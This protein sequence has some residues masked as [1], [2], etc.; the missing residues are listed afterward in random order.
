[1]P[2]PAFSTDLVSVIIP[3]YNH[4]KY[5]SKSIDSVL[6]QTHPYIEVVVVDDGSSDATREVSAGY[7][8]VK[9]IY[10]QNR[11]LSAARNTGID[12]SSG[13]YLVFLDADDWLFPDAVEIN[14]SYLRN[15]PDAGF[16][17]GA[18]TLVQPGIN[19]E[20]MATVEGD[21]YQ[22]LLRGNYI[23]MHATVMY[24]RNVFDGLRFDPSMR[25]CEDYDVY[26]KAARRFP[27]LHHTKQI[28]VYMIHD[29]NMSGNVP[30]MLDT[31]LKALN[32]Q[33]PE[34]RSEAEKESFRVG[35][36]FWINHYTQLMYT[37]LL[38]SSDYRR[39]AKKEAGEAML[40]QYRKDLYRKYQIL[41]PFMPLKKAMIRSKA[42]FLLRWLYKTG[43]YRKF[44]PAVGKISQGDFNRT[45]PFSKAF[46]YE[47]GGPVDRYY[48]ENFLQRNAPFIKGRVLEIGDN[49]YTL[50]YGGSKITK[51]D[52]LHVEEG[53]P[54][55]SF[56]GGLS[57]AP[58][59]PD[60]AFDCIILTQTLQFIYHYREALQTCYRILK[61]GGRLLLTVPGISHIDHGEWKEIW[62]WS[63]TRNAMAKLLGDHFP[64]ANTEV[65]AFGNVQV[66]AAFLYG[67]G[68][69]EL[70]KEQLDYSDT[71]Y[72]VIVTAVAVKPGA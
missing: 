2:E 53:N 49:A 56:Y 70:T 19:D 16:V 42:N 72:Q 7:A 52:V 21:H 12:Q 46:G 8:Q 33:E 37:Y 18:F 43:L 48:I 69:P 14:L 60:N 45:T 10:Q 59:I 65:T 26:L 57:D 68:L 32:R 13:R 1:M 54:N 67:M 4:G 71:H 39:G 38:N 27:V 24:S 25:S 9:Y 63:F 29:T 30:L 36:S 15:R 23:S 28:A 22:R 51:S 6:A 50:Q 20:V 11:G 62:Y 41:Q 58:Q 61:P 40:K 44:V 64:E 31:A 17:S 3:C 35:R 34:L 55:A 5:L 47:R 66:A